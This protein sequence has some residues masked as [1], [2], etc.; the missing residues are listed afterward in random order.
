MILI[1]DIM[2]ECG[3]HVKRMESN[4]KLEN[5]LMFSPE[6]KCNTKMEIL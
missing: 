3:D 6:K 4:R 1:C 5:P 2:H